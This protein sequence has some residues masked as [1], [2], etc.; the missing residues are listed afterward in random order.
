MSRFSVCGV[1][2]SCTRGVSRWVPPHRPPT[3]GHLKSAASAPMPRNCHHPCRGRFRPGSRPTPC[4]IGVRPGEGG[5]GEL[6]AHP[7]Q[8]RRSQRALAKAR[9]VSW[10]S[11][12]RMARLLACSS[13][14]PPSTGSSR[15]SRASCRQC[16][17]D[18]VL[19]VGAPQALKCP[20]LDR[21]IAVEVDA[22]GVDETAQPIVAGMSY[23]RATVL[24]VAARK[25]QAVQLD[26]VETAIAPKIATDAL[27]IFR[28]QVNRVGVWN[29]ASEDESARCSANRRQVPPASP[30]PAARRYRCA[31]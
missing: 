25:G 15:R 24:S 21:D 28:R 1:R 5:Q 22:L 8:R 23:W 14:L 30:V 13:T 11:M 31:A 29:V 7:G 26:R 9:C 20:S 2:T 12:R 6:L 19:L 16:N 10:P 3:S 27:A 4:V 18:P 17:R